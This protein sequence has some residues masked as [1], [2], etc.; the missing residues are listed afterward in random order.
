MNHILVMVIAMLI[1]SMF[2]AGIYETKM[3]KVS[4]ISIVVIMVIAVAFGIAW[5]SGHF[6]GGI[7]WD[8]ILQ[9][10]HNNKK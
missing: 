2:T 1:S 7:G 10:L 5:V 3:S 8:E 4:K 6:S 9:P